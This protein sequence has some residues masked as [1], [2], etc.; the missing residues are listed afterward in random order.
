MAKRMRPNEEPETTESVGDSRHAAISEDDAWSEDITTYTLTAHDPKEKN[1]EFLLADFSSAY[2]SCYIEGTRFD[3]K[4]TSV[5][6]VFEDKEDYNKCC[7]DWEKR[8]QPRWGIRVT[9]PNYDPSSIQDFYY[10]VVFACAKENIH[11]LK[12]E[13]VTQR[14]ATLTDVFL[15]S[16]KINHLTGCISAYCNTF[17]GWKKLMNTS[18]YH[19]PSKPFF[20]VITY[21]CHTNDKDIFK[22]YLKNIPYD[23]TAYGV[24]QGL[25][26]HNILPLAVSINRDR[27]TNRSMRAA[28]IFIYGLL[29][30]INLNSLLTES[31]LITTTINLNTLQEWINS[32]PLCNSTVKYCSNRSC[33]FSNWPNSSTEVKMSPIKH[34]QTPLQTLNPPLQLL[35]QLQTLPLPQFK[36]TRIEHYRFT[37]KH[38]VNNHQTSHNQFVNT[39]N[40]TI[41]KVMQFSSTNRNQTN[42]ELYCLFNVQ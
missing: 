26:K 12:A 17:E 18:G 29:S 32:M 27:I 31:P 10:R 13:E 36:T 40:I 39:S 34:L 41:N 28:F 3:Q 16:V 20:R 42:E 15:H 30:S 19:A 14:V 23:C 4:Q 21:L 1:L 37:N 2:P 9:D 38:S 24:K 25:H 33:S 8:W 22:I 5:F 35:T 11:A 7:D 6:V